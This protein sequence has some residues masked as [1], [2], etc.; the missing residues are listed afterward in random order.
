MRST[1]NKI[2]LLPG[3]IWFLAGETRTVQA[4]VSSTLPG[5]EVAG[6]T[7][8]LAADV[9]DLF[10]RETRQELNRV[11]MDAE[12]VRVPEHLPYK[13]FKV[14]LRS[15]ND[16]RIVAYLSLPVQGEVRE[17]KP[18]PVIVSACGYS[19]RQQSVML[20]EC[21]RGYAI[22]QVYPR[23]QGESAE[24][25]ELDNDKVSGYLESPEKAYYRGAYADIMRAIDFIAS[26]GDLDSSR[27]A[28]MGTSQGGGIALAVGALDHRV[29]AVVA[30]VPFLC[31][32]RFAARI[33]GS[34]VKSLLD[35]AGKNNEAGLTILDYFDPLQLAPNLKVPV[36][37]SAGGKD[38]ICPSATIQSVY[39]RLPGKKGIE[40]YPDLPHTSCMAFYN[41]S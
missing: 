11:P 31:N 10:W 5:Y 15:L 36:L 34:L 21:Q 25:Y 4:S 20:S 41:L 35:K 22:L 7:D 30:H 38:T 12:V 33:P 27:I 13:K 40:I 39:D 24:F 37:L 19:G 18:W 14:T 17:S 16:V 8:S 23:G 6:G 3:L 1:V 2:W 29:K 26:R 32:F 28:L 9:L